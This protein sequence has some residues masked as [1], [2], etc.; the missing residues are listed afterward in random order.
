M[1]E[2]SLIKNSTSNNQNCMFTCTQYRSPVTLMKRACVER[3]QRA[4]EAVDVTGRHVQYLPMSF[5]KCIDC[6]QGRK[7]MEENQSTVGAGPRA[8]PETTEPEIRDQA[9]AIAPERD[10]VIDPLCTCRKCG[11]TKPET[12]FYRSGSGHLERVCK[13]CKMQRAK[14]SKALRRENEQIRKAKMDVGAN[15]HSHLPV[16][17]RNAKQTARKTKT[18]MPSNATVLMGDDGRSQDGPSQVG[19]NNYSPLQRQVGGDHYKGFA[20]QPVE[21]ITRNKLGFLEGCIIKRL[22]R[23]NRIGGKGHEDLEKIQHEIELLLAMEG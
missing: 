2:N 13:A 16:C 23:Y 14:D 8:C 15:G 17:A 1:M 12:E 21:F 7:I 20:I 19:A 22:C 5:E 3:Q 6:E 9:A 18:N 10:D 4:Q 11:E